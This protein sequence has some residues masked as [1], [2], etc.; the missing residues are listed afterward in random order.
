MPVRFKGK[1][2]EI[3]TGVWED[4]RGS[5]YV[6]EISYRDPDTG[7][8]VREI[9]RREDALRSNRH[10]D[11]QTPKRA[12]EVERSGNL[13]SLEQAARRLK[14][15]G[16]PQRVLQVINQ[17][18]PKATK[19]MRKTKTSGSVKNMG[20][21]RRIHVPKP[22]TDRHSMFRGPGITPAGGECKKGCYG[23]DGG[24]RT[25]GQVLKRGIGR[26]HRAG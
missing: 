12:T 15:S 5:G 10:L 20:G 9:K 2:D 11:A 14:A 21:T 1:K 6:A 22:W 24:A 18:M 25:P 7:K 16:K 19:V 4:A 8:L 26:G 23:Q 3:E 13:G 17:D